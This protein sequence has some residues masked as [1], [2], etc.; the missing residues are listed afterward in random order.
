MKESNPQSIGKDLVNYLRGND[1]GDLR[2]PGMQFRTVPVNELESYLRMNRPPFDTTEFNYMMVL[3][4]DGSISREGLLSNIFNTPGQSYDVLMEYI[5][6]CNIVIS[7]EAKEQANLE[8][9]RYSRLVEALLDLTDRRVESLRARS[10]ENNVS[11]F[12]QLFEGDSSQSDNGGDLGQDIK[13][14][15]SLDWYVSQILSA[16]TTYNQFSSFVL[17][18]LYRRMVTL[19]VSPI[20]LALSEA[21]NYLSPA[22]LH[23]ITKDIS[24]EEW[25]SAWLNISEDDI[26]PGLFEVLVNIIRGEQEESKLLLKNIADSLGGDKS[27]LEKFINTHVESML[28]MAIKFSRSEVVEF[29]LRNCL[30][31]VKGSNYS[32]KVERVFAYDI[33]KLMKSVFS[34]LIRGDVDTCL[35]FLS[36]EIWK[37]YIYEDQ[38]EIIKFIILRSG[39]TTRDIL[40]KE[41][42]SNKD[43]GLKKF[44]VYI[45][46]LKN[47]QSDEEYALLKETISPFIVDH[48]VAGW[49][50]EPIGTN[51]EIMQMGTIHSLIESARD[52]E[53]DIILKAL[54]KKK[55]LTFD[56]YRAVLEQSETQ[57][58]KEKVKTLFSYY[59]LGLYLEQHSE[60]RNTHLAGKDQEKFISAF[61]TISKDEREKFIQNMSSDI[62]GMINDKFLKA[63]KKDKLLQAKRQKLEWIIKNELVDSADKEKV[64]AIMN[65]IIQFNIDSLFPD[66]GKTLDKKS[67]KKNKVKSAPP[68]DE[69][70]SDQL[71]LVVDDVKDISPPVALEE[72]KPAPKKKNK[73]KNKK[74]PATKDETEIEDGSQ[75]QSAPTESTQQEI[76]EEGWQVSGSNK[77]DKKNTV[78]AISSNKPGGPSGGGGAV[79]SSQGGE[80]QS[81]SAKD[82]PKAKPFPSKT[83]G[84]TK[85][86][87]SEEKLP[88]EPVIVDPDSYMAKLLKSPE[89]PTKPTLKKVE[90]SRKETPEDKLVVSSDKEEYPELVQ[91]KTP[92]VVKNTLVKKLDAPQESS[93]SDDEES[94]S[95]ASVGKLKEELVSSSKTGD[96]VTSG[97]KNEVTSTTI[98]ENPIISSDESKEGPKDEIVTSSNKDAVLN[99]EGKN[100]AGQ[101]EVTST[102]AVEHSTTSITSELVSNG[103][104]N[105]YYTTQG[106]NGVHFH[107]VQPDVVPV[108]QYP[109]VPVACNAYYLDAY[110]NPIYFYMDSQGNCVDQNGVPFKM[111]V[112]YAVPS[113]ENMGGNETNSYYGGGHGGG[114]SGSSRSRTPKKKNGYNGSKKHA[115]IVEEEN[116][117]GEFKEISITL[118]SSLPK[119][120]VMDIESEEYQDALQEVQKREAGDKLQVQLDDTHHFDIK[121]QNI[122]YVSISQDEDMMPKLPFSESPTMFI[123]GDK[124]NIDPII[125]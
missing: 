73:K 63:P 103:D 105:K 76:E 101:K 51:Y 49:N 62:K 65:S 19:G 8:H 42:F 117:Q 121:P 106:P 18:E 85:K 11:I 78:A 81:L 125:M 16:S 104:N 75:S 59:M 96:L 28:P 44:A 30:H 35:K 92:S 84:T 108:H 95:L 33:K 5:G 46:L 36:P 79:K 41:I 102:T 100:E 86:N 90:E 1:A 122:S 12:H 45:D 47:I 15:D 4:E 3:P 89:V 120:K 70:T 109:V 14:L 52:N 48:I 38:V 17:G 88:V 66:D 68:Q 24:Q 9:I 25:A 67:N 13:N 57:E 98:V 50:L 69:E 83:A 82:K 31:L 115:S 37:H 6:I 93:I 94:S 116:V 118:G 23:A 72:D 39:S 124:L 111:P 32:E 91:R 74:K 77:K 119:V 61:G 20:A 71:D 112:Y 114:G 43:L 64:D 107:S 40:L 99:S 26:A 58:L 34:A 53:E 2:I 27:V 7:S 97:S 56:L 29:I 123:G 80:K 22:E 21:G 10:I 60:G 113:H 54:Y 110:N 87:D 55:I